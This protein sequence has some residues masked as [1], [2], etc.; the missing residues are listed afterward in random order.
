MTAGVPNGKVSRLTENTDQ[1]NLSSS[2]F[3]WREDVKP[4][5]ELEQNQKLKLQ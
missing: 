4:A 5:G 1:K 3:F 2:T